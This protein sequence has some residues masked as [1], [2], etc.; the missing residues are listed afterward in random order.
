MHVCFRRVP[1]LNPQHDHCSLSDKLINFLSLNEPK[2]FPFAA[3][4]R[5][6]V[7]VR[8]GVNIVLLEDSEPCVLDDG[9]AEG[10][11]LELM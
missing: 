3:E 9:V 5:L 10:G 8:V 2:P 6:E 11:D 7:G 4:E 1:E